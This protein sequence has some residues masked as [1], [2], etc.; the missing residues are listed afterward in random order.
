MADKSLIVVA[1]R[2]SGR[3]YQLLES[4]RDFGR[5]RLDAEDER[6]DTRDAHVVATR[7]CLQRLGA[8]EAHEGLV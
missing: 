5:A 8:D 6:D 3:R 7:S 2:A 1:D 4:V